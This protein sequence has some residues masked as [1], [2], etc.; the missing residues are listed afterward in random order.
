MRRLFSH[1]VRPG[2]QIDFNVDGRWLNGNLVPP[3]TPPAT[4]PAQRFVR[5]D[6]WLQGIDLELA[7]NY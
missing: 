4:S 3:F 1:L 6:A 2:D 5:S 7:W